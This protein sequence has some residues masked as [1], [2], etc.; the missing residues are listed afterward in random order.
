MPFR[1]NIRW[2]F[3]SL[4]MRVRSACERTRL[5]NSATSRTGAG[6]SGS[7][8]GAPGRSN[9][10]APCWSR[11][12]RRPGRSRSTTSRSRVR[13][14]HAWASWTDAGPNA[15]R[16]LVTSRSSDG[17]ASRSRPSQACAEVCAA[18]PAAPHTARGGTWTSGTSA[19]TPWASAAGGCCGHCADSA[20]PSS[21]K[22]RGR[23]S[24][25]TRPAAASAAVSTPASC[26]PSSRLRPRSTAGWTRGRSIRQSRADTRWMV[27]R[28]SAMR[29][30]CRLSSSPARSSG[31]NPASRDHRP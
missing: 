10:S 21:L 14:D 12:A 11:K 26:R 16:Y 7:G 17:P 13:P 1:V 23:S 8:R 4:M 30:T 25:R 28:M 27:P 2:R 20:A 29:T 19:R 15:A 3:G 24:T 22:V 9:S 31:R 5:S 6:L 18:C